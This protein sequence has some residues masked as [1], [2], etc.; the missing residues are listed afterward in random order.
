MPDA[1][2]ETMSETKSETKSETMSETTQDTALG[3]RLATRIRTAGPMGVDSFMAACLGDASDGYYQHN[4]PF[5]VAGD[6]ITAPEISGLFGEMC[7][8]YLAHMFEL[9]GQP[10]DAVIAELGPGR[11]TLMRDMRSVW[12]TLMPALAS[13]PVHLVET[14]P[15]LR[16]AQA[17]VIAADGTAPNAPGAPEI[18]W[19]DDVASLP[20]VPLFGIANEFFDA[21]AVAQC[22]WRGNAADGGWHHRL[23]GL[24]G[25]DFSFVNG[26][27]LST[28]ELADYA[29]TLPPEP[30]DG[31]IAEICAAGD[32]VIAALARRISRHGG[33]MLIVDYGRNGNAGDSLQAVADHRPV[34]VFHQP[35]TADLSHWVDFAALSRSAAAHGCRLI[36]PVPQGRFLM[37]IGLAQR[38][39]Q[40]GLHGEAEERRSLLAAVDRLTSPAQMGE[41]FK[42]A[43][44]V[45]Q[46]TGMPPGFESEAASPV[47]KES[48]AESGPES[49]PESGI[50]SHEGPGGNRGNGGA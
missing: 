49:G 50:G 19:H 40:A 47:M 21:L 28:A 6:F 3:E 23:V 16:R 42:V 14:S 30:A 46:G 1:M 43:L 12:Q 32:Q 4:D 36:G 13:R 7:G 33:A 22:V 8:L 37:R 31:D 11:G 9:A 10:G 29:A 17:A 5:G 24:R 20:E 15:T 41:V 39:E 38:A 26:P 18:K 35:G 2:S 25:D 48:R 34:D 44:L 45:P 27:A